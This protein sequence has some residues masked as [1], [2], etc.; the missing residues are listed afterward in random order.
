MPRGS[1]Y[2]S[3]STYS[4]SKG[5]EFIADDAV[6]IL[7]PVRDDQTEVL[8]YQ[9]MPPADTRYRAFEDLKLKAYHAIGVRTMPCERNAV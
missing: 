8:V 9:V 7:A 2:V 5:N 1:F 3:K 6:N 4:V